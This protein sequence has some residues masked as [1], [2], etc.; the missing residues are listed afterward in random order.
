MNYAQLIIDEGMQDSEI[1][2]YATE[3]LSESE[4][5]AVIVKS[6]LQFARQEKQT[7][8][9]EQMVEIINQT[10]ALIKTLMRHQQITI[11]MDAPDDL[12]SIMCRSQQ[13]QQVLMNLLT[14]ARDALNEKYSGYDVNKVINIQCTTFYKNEAQWLR[15]VIMDYGNGIP[16][17]IM[18]RIFEPF[19]TTKRAQLCVRKPSQPVAPF[20]SRR[21]H[22]CWSSA[23][24][25]CSILSACI[26][27][28]PHRPALQQCPRG[29]GQ[30][31][32]LPS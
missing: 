16:Q 25:W 10:L 27:P 21:Q 17:S 12:P 29:Q 26:A 5:V 28:R 13:I 9:E 8:K 22:H 30:L 24:K 18:N 14:N 20:G 2:A 7:F 3:I 11:E 23:R 31:Y 19:Y 1:A 32:P 4:R 15:V 6:L